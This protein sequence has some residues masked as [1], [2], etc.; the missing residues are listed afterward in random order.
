MIDLSLKDGNFLLFYIMQSFKILN[1]DYNM[2]AIS[3]RTLA[4]YPQIGNALFM[5]Q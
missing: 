3:P 4:F 2:S 1:L 5:F